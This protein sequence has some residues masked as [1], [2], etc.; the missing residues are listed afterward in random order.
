MKPPTPRGE[1]GRALVL[2]G[3]SAAEIARA[4]GLTKRHAFRLRAAHRAGRM[5]MPG[6]YLRRE[7]LR[8]DKQVVKERARVRR[9]LAQLGIDGPGVLG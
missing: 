1:Q 6:E 2:L 7:R 5:T 8:V 4:T 9:L 3:H